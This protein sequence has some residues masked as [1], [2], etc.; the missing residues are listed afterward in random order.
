MIKNITQL[1]EIIGKFK[2]L[3]RSGWIN[4]KV[5]DSE[6]DAEHSFSVALL[7]FLLAPDDLDK[8]KCL[9]LALIHDLAEI[10]AGDFTPYDNITPQ[11]KIHRERQG[12]AQIAEELG[13]NELIDLF[14][15][16]ENKSSQ[17]AIFI[18]ALD[19]IDNVI[20]ATYYDSHQRA[21]EPLAAEFCD[22]A[23]RKISTLSDNGQLSEIKQILENLTNR[24]N[25]PI[26]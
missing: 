1:I 18:N 7:A 6:S 23:Y 4:K 9:K 11:E 24:A 25:Q 13:V 20:T 3:K 8:E 26:D 17:E 22:Y 2:D 16:F 14:N 5:I 10:Y 12:I 21:K 19:K 15:D